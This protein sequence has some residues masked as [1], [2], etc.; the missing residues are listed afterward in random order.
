MVK[1]LQGDRNLL[2]YTVIPQDDGARWGPWLLPI[3]CV[4]SNWGKVAGDNR[5]IFCK[6]R[7]GDFALF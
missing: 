1:L 4:V 6:V 7:N 5:L 3:L 2:R